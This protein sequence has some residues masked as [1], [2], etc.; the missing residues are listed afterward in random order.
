M[1]CVDFIFSMMV[2]IV[3][4]LLSLPP[5]YITTCTTVRSFFWYFISSW[6]V[7]IQWKKRKF[8]FSRIK[9]T[10]LFTNLLS[11]LA[12][13]YLILLHLTLTLRWN[14]VDTVLYQCCA[15]LFR[16]CLNVGHWRCI[17]VGFCFILKVGLTLF[18]ILSPTLISRWN[19]SWFNFY[20]MTYKCSQLKSLNSSL[21]F[22]IDYL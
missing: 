13:F 12:L 14:N 20:G 19:V 5:L 1:Q 21:A 18:K 11:S 2:T 16:R 3:T 9:T 10:P 4:M 17:N 6:I 22:E 7:N 15:T 8:S